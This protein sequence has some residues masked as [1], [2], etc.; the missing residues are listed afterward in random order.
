MC[1]NLIQVDHFIR[2]SI[3]WIFKAKLERTYE[4]G[5]GQFDNSSM[6]SSDH[7]INNRLL[8]VPSL[9]KRESYRGAA[10]SLG[11]IR[12]NSSTQSFRQLSNVAQHGQTSVKKTN[13]TCQTMLSFPSPS[14]NHH[15]CRSASGS[16]K[17]SGHFANS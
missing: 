14:R 12:R 3:L 1:I 2:I 10:S 9:K 13:K 5:R 8:E 16:T 6:L 11:V 7:H 4:A 17:V 15:I